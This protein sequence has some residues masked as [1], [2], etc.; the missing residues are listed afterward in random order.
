MSVHD[1]TPTTIE[2]IKRLARDISK[3]DGVAHSIGLD[4][5]SS[6]A[7]FS[8]YQHARRSI[9]ASSTT[10]IASE[11]S[12]FISV[13]WRDPKTKISGS[14]IIQVALPK[15]LDEIVPSR[16][17]KH[18]RG[19]AY[20]KRSASDLIYCEMTSDSS[21]ALALACKAARALQFMAA[22]GLQPSSKAVPVSDGRGSGLPGRDHG[23]SWFDPESR[24]YIYVDE[25]YAAA[26]KDR[27]DERADWG[28]RNGWEVARAIWPGMY[29]PEGGSELYLATEGKRGLPIGPVLADLSHIQAAT[30]PENCKQVHVPDGEYFRSPGQ[31]RDANAKVLKPKQK[32]PSRAAADTVPFKMVMASGR[33]PNAKMAVPTHQRVGQLLKD[34]LSATRDRA[35]VANRLGSVRSELDDWVQMEYDHE[36]LPNDVFFELYYRERVTVPDDERGLAGRDVHIERLMEAKELIGSAYPDCQPVRA[37]L[38]K[39]DLAVQSLMNWK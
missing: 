11:F 39:L 10:T 31:E 29:Y 4:R 17:Y 16:N 25:P 8:N 15:A 12:T 13:Y 3:H 7:G 5:A 33:R 37:L 28:R 14:K 34:V 20:F 24:R 6:R 9:L 27:Q 2:G 36:A 35:G 18:A 30:V 38:R 32:R 19:L 26:V 23:S 21:S 1:V 22:T